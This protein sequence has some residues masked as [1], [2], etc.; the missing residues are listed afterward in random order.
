MKI[1]IIDVRNIFVGFLILW[2]PALKCFVSFALHLSYNI[3]TMQDNWDKHRDTVYYHGFFVL[4]NY[5]IILAISVPWQRD[6]VVIGIG[7]I[8]KESS[9]TIILKEVACLITVRS[10]Q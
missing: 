7:E 6:M 10:R 4:Y 9:I 3:I 8:Y 2:G 5:S 1:N